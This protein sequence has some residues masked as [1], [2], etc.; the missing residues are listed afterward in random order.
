MAWRGQTPGKRALHLR[1][2]ANDG[3]ALLPSM[4]LARNLT[5]EVEVFLPLIALMA[6]DVLV[7]NASIPVRLAALVWTAAIAL[8]PLLN[9]R[10]ARLGDLVAGTTVVVQPR[11]VLL[12]DLISTASHQNPAEAAAPGVEADG[13]PQLSFTK[14]QLDVYG[15]YEL[16]VL[17]D[18]LRK[19]EATAN[20]ELLDIICD[21]IM[22]KIRWRRTA[23]AVSSEAFLRAFYAAQ[24]GR[25]EHQMLLGRR[26]ERKRH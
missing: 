1:V 4:V 18:V 17:E 15:I 3:G 24:R 12:E 22:H 25:L 26:R 14:Q 5:R 9:Q 2:V 6:P 7:P 16:Q 21:K 10:G 20:T 13:V 19:H 8:L 11:A 23:A